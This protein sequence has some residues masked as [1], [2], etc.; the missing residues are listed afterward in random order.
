MITIDAKNH[1]HAIGFYND[2]NNSTTHLIINDCHLISPSL[3]DG[4]DT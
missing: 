4:I 2:T 3:S 1:S